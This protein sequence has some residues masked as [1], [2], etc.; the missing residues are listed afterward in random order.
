MS[1]G[2]LDEVQDYAVA[3][4]SISILYIVGGVILE[5]IIASK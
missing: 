3:V 5:N 2:A 1:S 4:V